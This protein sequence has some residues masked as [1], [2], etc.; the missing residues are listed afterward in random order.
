MATRTDESGQER[1][2]SAAYQVRV[3]PLDD[4]DGLLRMALRGEAKIHVGSQ[5]AA[6][7]LA[8]AF[9]RTFH[10]DW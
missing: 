5:T 3:L 2:R 7:K 6:Q 1:L 9:S 4:P 10:F 8:R